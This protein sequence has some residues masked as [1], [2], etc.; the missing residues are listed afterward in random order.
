[1][2]LSLV[3]PTYNES[4]N[5]PILLERISIHLADIPKEVIIV[6]DNSP[7]KTWE[8]AHSLEH[9]YSWLR[10]I[11]R[12]TEKGLSSAVMAGFEIAEGDLLAVMDSDLQH[13]EK[14]L[15]D[16]Y[17]AFQ[18]GADLVVGSRKA[19]GGQVEDWSQTRKFI[20]WTATLMSKIALR[21]SVSDP[22]SGFFALK[23]SVYENYKEQINPRGFKILLEFLARSKNIKIAEVG[24]TFKGRIHG[25]SK[26]SH[27]VILDYIFALYELSIGKY[28]PI[29]FIQYGIIGTIGLIIGTLIIYFTEIFTDFDHSLSLAL[30]IE[31]S[32]LSNFFLNNYWTF[33][34]KKLVGFKKLLRGLI[35]FHAICLSG[36]LINHAI[37][38]KLLE[39]GIN[40]YLSNSIGYLLAAIW[41]YIINVNITWKGNS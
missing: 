40:I 34:T 37:G 6:D 5:I 15:I 9:K 1:M 26:L 27:K 19:Q 33:K 14:A 22:M 10:V 24:Y 2:L 3:I 30:S 11:R 41:N 38:I 8:V 13:D 36:A 17:R 18:N 23:R 39:F 35:L 28:V 21:H 7:D 4:I 29:K 31:M 25:E 16:F 12:M 32:L 20:S